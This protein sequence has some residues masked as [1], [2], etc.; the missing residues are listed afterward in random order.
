MNPDRISGYPASRTIL[1]EPHRMPHLDP[2][3]PLHTLPQMLL[4]VAA[5]ERNIG[6]KEA[7]TREHGMV[8]APHIKTTM[9]GEIVR[10]QLPGSWGVTVATTAQAAQAVEWGAT[11]ILIA[12]EVLFRGH[13]EQ[14]RAW[15]AASPE[16][17][18][19]CLADSE[20]GVQAMA[21]VF[22]D[23]PQA[24]ERADRRRNPRRPHRDPHCGRSRA[25]GGGDSCGQRA[26]AGRRQRLRGRGTEHPDG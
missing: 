17:E 16:L 6:I 10:R 13:L 1:K 19:Y 14:L 25:A 22:E 15:L 8:L 24:A 23:S 11:R 3:L 18:I 20:A 4:D 7:W 21:E 9:T 2:A 12:N 26:A 5:V